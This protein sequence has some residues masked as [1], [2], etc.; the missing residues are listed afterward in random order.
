[1]A[2]YHIHCIDYMADTVLY[3]DDELLITRG[4]SGTIHA[5][6]QN[7]TSPSPDPVPFVDETAKRVVDADMES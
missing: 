4:N 2:Q 7:R 5:M 1:M 3:V 6:T